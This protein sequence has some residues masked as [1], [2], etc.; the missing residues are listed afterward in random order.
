MGFRLFEASS[1]A[2]AGQLETC[3]SRDYVL[4]YLAWNWSVEAWGRCEVRSYVTSSM[5]AL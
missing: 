3:Y 5:V 2:V 1:F 4:S